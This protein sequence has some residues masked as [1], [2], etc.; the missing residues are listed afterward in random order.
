MHIQIRVFVRIIAFSSNRNYVCLYSNT[1]I[2]TKDSVLVLSGI[3]VN[4]SQLSGSERIRTD[5]GSGN[6]LSK[7]LRFV[8]KI[9]NPC[10]IHIFKNKFCMHMCNVT[11]NCR[12]KILIEQHKTPKKQWKQTGLVVTYIC[13]SAIQ[14][15]RVT[16]ENGKI[17]FYVI[18]FYFYFC[19][20]Y[21]ISLA[22]C[23]RA[24]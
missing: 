8:H 5:K 6:V 19:L 9:F 14:R 3:I 4:D 12:I 16:S 7:I 20:A 18:I 15:S 10:A 21:K 1:N 23:V 17:L 2:P 22:P 24:A 13:S 11:R